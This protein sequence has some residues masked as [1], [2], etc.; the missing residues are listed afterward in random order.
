MLICRNSIWNYNVTYNNIYKLQLQQ[1]QQQQQ[2]QLTLHIKQ[3]DANIYKYTNSI[4]NIN[5]EHV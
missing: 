1:Q 4:T 5:K 3:P 2:Q